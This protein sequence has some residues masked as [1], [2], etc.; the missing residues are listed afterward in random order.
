MLTHSTVICD[1]QKKQDCRCCIPWNR[2]VDQGVFYCQNTRNT[3]RDTDKYNFVHLNKKSRALPAP[4]FTKLPASQYI[5]AGIPRTNFLKRSQEPY[6]WPKFLLCFKVPSGFHC[7]DFYETRNCLTEVTGKLLCH[8]RPIVL[9]QR[10]TTPTVRFSLAARGRITV[11]CTPNL[12]NYHVTL[13]TNMAAGRIIPLGGRVLE[14]RLLWRIK[15]KF[16][17]EHKY[18]FYVSKYVESLRLHIWRKS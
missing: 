6:S 13:L 11:S 3:S 5:S 1:W 8:S 12:L 17:K 9:R 18:L 15:P 10:T 14:A 2:K 7:T 16:I 4:I